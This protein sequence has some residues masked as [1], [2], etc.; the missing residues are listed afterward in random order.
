MPLRTRTRPDGTTYTVMVRNFHPDGTEFLPEEFT[1]P[2]NEQTKAFYRL[3]NSMIKL[4]LE[5]K[6][7]AAQKALEQEQEKHGE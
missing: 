1:V 7:L 5:R 3:H 2:Y 4:G 6:A